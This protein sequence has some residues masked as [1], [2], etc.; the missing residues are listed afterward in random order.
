MSLFVGN[1]SKSV[2]D[3]DLKDEFGRFGQCKCIIKGSFAFIDYENDGD[4]E[5]AK[6]ELINKNLGG[7]NIN[8]EWSKKSIKFDPDSSTRPDASKRRTRDYI[9]CYNCG[10]N[11]GNFARDCKERSVRRRSRDRYDNRRDRNDNRRDKYDNRRRDSRSRSPRGSRSPRRSR[12][13]N[14]SNS[15]RG[16]KGRGN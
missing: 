10:K 3:D 8:I 14:D 9:I 1:L 13:R 4:A 12:D 15:D 16:Y 2:R 11:C 7:L 5:K 6:T